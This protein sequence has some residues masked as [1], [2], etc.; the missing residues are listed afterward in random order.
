MP[1][2]IEITKDFPPSRERA[3]LLELLRVVTGLQEA[4]ISIP[5]ACRFQN[6]SIRRLARRR[7]TSEDLSERESPNI[8]GR[9]PNWSAT[10]FWTTMEKRADVNGM[11]N[12]SGGRKIRHF[13]LA[14]A[15]FAARY[16]QGAM[17]QERICAKRRDYCLGVAW[18]RKARPGLF[19]PG[20]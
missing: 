3:V 7:L 17:Q 19:H 6:R 9:P 8:R 1:S 13:S 18:R 2:V 14:G 10:G 12:L 16:C 4:G 20:L 5:G 15:T 11:A